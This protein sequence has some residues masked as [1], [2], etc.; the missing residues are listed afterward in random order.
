[1]NKKLVLKSLSSSDIDIDKWNPK[2][3]EDV[4]ISYDIEI[5]YSDNRFGTNYFYVTVATPES[6]R[7]HREGDFLVLNRTLVL[8]NYNYTIVESVVSK[9]LEDCS[10]DTWEESCSVLQRYFLWEYEDYAEEK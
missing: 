2:T 1:M 5:G 3:L 10:R 6:L 4:F 9:I 7:K 8:S